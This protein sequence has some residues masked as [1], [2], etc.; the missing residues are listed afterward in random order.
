LDIALLAS[1]EFDNTVVAAYRYIART[2]WWDICRSLWRRSLGTRIRELCWIE[3]I[4]ADCASQLTA[5]QVEIALGLSLLACIVFD[6]AVCI[7]V[8]KNKGR[9]GSKKN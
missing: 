5:I 6:A 4:T 9:D 7:T 2:R 1:I 8:L 3:K